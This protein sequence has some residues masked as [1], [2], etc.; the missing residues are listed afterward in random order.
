MQN[1]AA[2]TMKTQVKLAAPAGEEL[3]VAV[4][5]ARG[6]PITDATVSLEGN[7]NHAGMA[8]VMAEGVTDDADG[9]AD[10]VY[11][12]P[13]EF[14]MNG[15]WIM[16]VSVKLAD[17][18]TETHDI[19]LTVT[20]DGVEIH[21][22]GGADSMSSGDMAMDMEMD[23]D[24][25]DQGPIHVTD[26]WVRA[27]LPMTDNTALYFTL[28]NTTDAPV[29]L[30]GVSVDGLT[31]EMHESTMENGVARMEPRPDGFEIPAGEHLM[32]DEGGKHVMLMG[33]KE[34][35]EAGKEISVTLEFD[36]ADSVTFMAPISDEA[37]PAM[38]HSQH[39][40]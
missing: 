37:M 27:S 11:H 16:T 31:A 39:G 25:V 10:G 9:A 33:V 12:L 34:P 13:F 15:D 28:H 18:A 20:G 24:T 1:N 35:L 5:D 19:D 30:T 21:Q 36:G 22:D 4:T 26:A 6:A 40:G 2:S 17:G 38:D 7:M 3:S 8:P 29:R 32:L 14:S 23:H